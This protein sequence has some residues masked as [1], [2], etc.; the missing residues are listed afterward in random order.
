MGHINVI[1]FL[2]G[3]VFSPHLCGRGFGLQENGSG[4]SSTPA[5]AFA[6]LQLPAEGLKPFCLFVWCFGR[7]QLLSIP[8]RPICYDQV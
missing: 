1:L 3:R 5:G 6:H 8:F 4:M 2:F 7:L